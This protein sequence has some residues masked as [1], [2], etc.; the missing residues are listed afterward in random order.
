MSCHLVAYADSEGLDQIPYS[1]G[2][3]RA[4]TIWAQ[5]FK[6]NDVVS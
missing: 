5:L 6:A 3:I 1:H 4:F 2:L